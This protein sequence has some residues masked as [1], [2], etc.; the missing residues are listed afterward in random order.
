VT[1]PEPAPQEAGHAPQL[2]PAQAEAAMTGQ[3]VV[4]GLLPLFTQ[5]LPNLLAQALSQTQPTRLCASCLTRRLQ[6]E[7]VNGSTLEAIHAQ[8]LQAAGLTADDP[9]AGQID[10]TQFMPE[11][12]RASMPE[13]RPP[14]TTHNGDELCGPCMMPSAN[15]GA[16]ALRPKLLVATPGLSIPAFQAAM[17]GNM[18]G[19]PR[20]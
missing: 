14:V 11:D 1:T 19:F 6:W 12:L 20:R 16:E 15:P 13:M 5:V 4:Q 18:P 9:R 8:A 7:T 3:A 17:N 10:L 2:T